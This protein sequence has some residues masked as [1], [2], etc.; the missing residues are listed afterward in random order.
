MCVRG[1]GRKF[2]VNFVKKIFEK[3]CRIK[4]RAY[5]CTRNQ[6]MIDASLAQLVEHD[7]LNVGVQGSSPWRCTEST[8]FEAERF[9][10]GVFYFTK[11][12]IIKI[13]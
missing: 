5:L 4:N 8:I 10:D 9:G 12:I 7:T 11:Y 3:F 13:L 6:M 2:G 1:R